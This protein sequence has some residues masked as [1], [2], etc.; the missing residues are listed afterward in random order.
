M[1]ISRTRRNNPKVFVPEFQK[2]A[3]VPCSLLTW[4]ILPR[5]VVGRSRQ[6]ELV[7]TS[8]VLHA[9]FSVD[10]NLLVVDSP[11]NNLFVCRFAISI[12]NHKETLF[13]CVEIFS[14]KT[15]RNVESR[16]MLDSFL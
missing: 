11:D 14:L 1:H 10:T 16:F 6:T 12:K 13:S 5:H 3:S 9:A 2:F 7:V 15:L 4:T 8:C